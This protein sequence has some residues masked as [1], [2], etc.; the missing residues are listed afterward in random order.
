MLEHALVN[1][2]DMTPAL[3]ELRVEQGTQIF[4]K[5]NATERQ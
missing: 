1:E 5:G 2:M 3:G 4:L